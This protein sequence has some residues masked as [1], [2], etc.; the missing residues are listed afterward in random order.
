LFELPGGP[1]AFALGAEYRKE[2]NS[3]DFDELTSSGATFLNALT[4]FRPPALK[5]KEAYG[6][7][8]F[9]LLKDLPFAQ[10][11]SVN[12]AGRVSDYNNSTGTV[13][14]YNIQ[15]IYAPVEDI[16]FRAAYATSVRA[17][18]QGD[19]FSAQGENFNTIADPCSQANINA[20]PNRA[21]NCA[22]AGVPTVASAAV[23]A[24]CTTLGFPTVTV[25]AP[26]AN[27][28]TQASNTSILS[29]GNP[30]LSEERGKSLTLGAVIKPRF[31]P[32]L[33]LTVDYYNIKVKSLIATL[34]A[35][36]V[37]NL[38]YDS[39]TGIGIP[40]CASINRDPATGFFNVPA[41]IAGP[42]N[43]AAQRTK[44][45]DFDIDYRRTFD[46]GDR[47][48]L[49]VIATRVLT[50]NNFTNVAAPTEP[51]RQLSELGDP[52]WAGSLI[53]DYDFG[54]I[55]FRYAARYIGKQ[56][57]NG[58]AYETLFPHTRLC[59]VSG[60]TPNTGG[61]NGAAVPCTAGTL[62]TVAPNNADSVARKW[63]PDVLYHD[64]RIGFDVG[65][66][67]RFYAGVNNLL[68]RQPPLGLLGTAGGDPFDSFGRNFFFGFNADF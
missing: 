43:F 46:N 48:R 60:V 68:D 55:D 37:V 6:E 25:G 28:P 67:F 29:G 26:W 17:P 54:D 56:V 49:S 34:T 4:D 32:G 20:G 19:L 9:P 36:Q 23:S 11:L 39:S 27:C 42:T 44:G 40:A 47:L 8:Y 31:L 3:I 35:Q 22:A 33:T 52:Q 58:L 57:N 63:Y 50:L 64:I 30:T 1:I 16:R 66:D 5:V 13:Y 45:I 51:N 59:P 65:N 12:L 10:E 7:I 62:V 18:S 21:A 2:K 53:F 41:L 14:A 61:I 15:G 38:C 24:I